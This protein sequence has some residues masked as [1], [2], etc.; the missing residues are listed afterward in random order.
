MPQVPT[1]DGPQVRTAPLQP[2]LQRTPD[3]SS[4]A[5]A[6]AQGL[7]QVAEVADKI[8]LRDAQDA[9]FKAQDELRNAWGKQQAALRSQF[10]A[11]QAGQYEVEAAKWWE[12]ARTK[13]TSTLSPRAQAIAGRA[14]G[15]FK[16]AVDA[17]TTAY[18][19]REKSTARRVNFETLQNTLIRDASVNAT[20]AT[21]AAIAAATSKQIRDNAIAYATAEGY[22]DSA[23]GEKMANDL[24]DRF[25]ATMALTLANSVDGRE[26]AGE[27][28][29]QFGGSMPM[30]T[31]ARVEERIEIAAEQAKT[32]AAKDLYGNL[33]FSVENNVWPTKAQYEQLRQ[34]DPMAAANLKAAETAQKKALKVEA[35]GG[36]IKTDTAAY[37]E[38][39]DRVLAQAKGGPP[40]DVLAYRDRVSRS[41]LEEVKKMQ[42]NIGKPGK[43]ERMFTDER[44]IDGYRPEKMKSTDPEW[45]ALRK[46]LESKLLLVRTEK[47]GNITDEEARKALDEEFVVGKVPG[48]I[49]GTNE[50]PRWE[51]TEEELKAAQF[52]GS[53]PAAPAAPAPAR[54]PIGTLYTINGADRQAITSKLRERGQA[55]TEDNIQL[56]YKNWKGL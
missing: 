21:A 46:R 3:V 25:H 22:T 17:D 47:G 10:K 15:D 39:R 11:D 4:G 20:P 8:D 41:D 16:R 54:K 31:R 51:M 9:A 7:G 28:L 48:R 50:K 26:R 44:T 18:V 32:K 23:V 13:Y 38:L 37:F 27:Y 19:E 2:V 43:V 35:S 12:E 6:L 33:R 40:V 53:A 42:E 36:S 45:L 52:P 5:R 49:W 34:V 14:L 29:T 55:V 56:M 30:E 24:L 1:Y